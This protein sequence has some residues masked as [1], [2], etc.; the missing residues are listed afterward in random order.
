MNDL[1]SI[2][3]L[4]LS[5]NDNINYENINIHKK[6]IYLITCEKYLA[7]ISAKIVLK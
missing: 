1:A 4:F 3:F 5:R 6:L 7:A 2:C